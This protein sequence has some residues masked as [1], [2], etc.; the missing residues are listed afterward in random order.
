MFQQLISNLHAKTQNMYLK[1]QHFF[2]K[3][4]NDDDYDYEK[5]DV[6]NDRFL[7]TE[8]NS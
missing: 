4:D 6:I 8:T 3:W 2:P 1:I 5:L 7:T